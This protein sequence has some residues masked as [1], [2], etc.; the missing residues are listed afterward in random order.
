MIKVK[1]ASVYSTLQEVCKK[2]R[3]SG[4]LAEQNTC[5]SVYWIH[6]LLDQGLWVDPYTWSTCVRRA[7]TV[8][9]P[10]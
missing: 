3:Y 7:T 2:L 4:E 1:V 9:A 10:V 6:P 5:V 8:G